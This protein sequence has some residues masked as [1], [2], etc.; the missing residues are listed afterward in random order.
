MKRQQLTACFRF[1]FVCFLYSTSTNSILQNHTFEKESPASTTSREL[2]YRP[3]LNAFRE[4]DDMNA[5]REE[6]DMIT[7]DS[8]STVAAAAPKRANTSLQDDGSNFFERMESMLEHVEESILETR[9]SDEIDQRRKSYNTRKSYDTRKSFDTGSTD[10]SMDEFS[11]NRLRSHDMEEGEEEETV[12]DDSTNVAATVVANDRMGSRNELLRPPEPVPFHHRLEELHAVHVTR[13]VASFQRPTHIMVDSAAASPAHTNLTMDATMMNMNDTMASFSMV[14]DDDNSSTMTPI[15]DRYRLDPDDNS[16]GVKVVPNQR[17]NHRVRQATPL[18]TVYSIEKQEREQSTTPLPAVYYNR[19]QDLSTPCSSRRHDVSTS[20]SS[21]RHEISTPMSSRRHEISTPMSLPARFPGSVS[22]RKK[23]RKT[24]HPKTNLG[25]E[26][27]EVSTTIDEENRHPNQV[28]VPS[29]DVKT[30]HPSIKN[31]GRELDQVSTIDEENRHPNQVRVP[32][33][34]VKTPLP[35]I[36]VPPLRSRSFE[37]R[38]KARPKTPSASSRATS[39]PGGIDR[40]QT[41]LTDAFVEKHLSTSSHSKSDMASRSYSGK[42]IENITMAEYEGAPR[43]VSMQVTRDE[44]NAAASA[45]EDYFLKA[46]GFETT[47]EAL[48]LTEKQAYQVVGGES[49]R[50]GKSIL[51]SLCHWRRLLMY[52]DPQ[53]GMVFAINQNQN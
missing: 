33:R 39:L 53:H 42:W 28:R 15:L 18:S 23:Y 32:S 38:K 9:P 48:E 5:F 21:R 20:M 37:P 30:P 7:L 11:L 19:K 3:H 52:R 10:E 26:L 6:D 1:V 4:E 17:R 35:S 43:V 25:R 14:G 22:E 41:P 50:K 8:R 24:P 36:T 40:S 45:L 16:I 47:Y 31:L 2:D 29:R 44:V 27:D 49:E 51:M 34:D 46:P 13:P 12:S